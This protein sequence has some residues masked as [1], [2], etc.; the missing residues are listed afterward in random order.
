MIFRRASKPP[1]DPEVWP[2]FRVF[3]DSQQTGPGP[4]AVILQ[5]DHSRLAGE[6]AARLRPEI[7]GD[8]PPEVVEAIAQH[9]F[10]WLASDEDQLA[11]I[12]DTALRPFPALSPEETLPSWIACLRLAE[13][14]SPLNGVIVSRHFCA[15]A[16]SDPARG[17]FAAQQNP[18]R[19]HLERELNIPAED[20]DRWTAAIGFCDLVSLYLCSGTHDPAEF[21]LAHP[22]LP[23]SSDAPKLQVHWADGQPRFEPSPF[24]RNACLSARALEVPRLR[25][26]ALEWT[27]V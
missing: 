14:A 18:R 10:G 20:L 3:L 12:T 8:L 15:L 26:L 21:P 19:K 7:F 23:T 16:Q 11:H 1:S 13:T 22:A 5:P 9:D 2:A 25:P 6:I 27:P 4:D 24:L 17:D